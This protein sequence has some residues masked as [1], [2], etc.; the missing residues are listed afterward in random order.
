M[1]VPSRP[2]GEPVTD[3]FG[4]VCGVIIYHQVHVEL[5]GHTGLYLVE[6]L[7]ELA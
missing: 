4:F 2:F 3:Q 7:S 1:H 6:E 5:A